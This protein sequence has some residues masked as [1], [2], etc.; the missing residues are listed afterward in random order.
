VISR[1]YHPKSPQKSGPMDPDTPRF[2]DGISS[3]LDT[4]LYKLTMHCAALKYF[5]DVCKSR[6][7]LDSRSNSSLITN[8]VIEDVTYG[9]T[10]RTPHMKLSR[11]AYLWLLEQINS[12]LLITYVLRTSIG[13]VHEIQKLNLV[14]LS[15]LRVSTEEIKFLKSACP[16]LNEA[17]L[18]YLQSFRLKPVEQIDIK[19]TPV[20]DTGNVNDLGNLEYAI[21]GLWVETILYEIPLLALTSEAYFKFC[22]KDWDYEGQE[23][24]AYEKGCT[25]LKNGCIFSEF[26]SRRRRDYHTQDLVMKGLCRAAEDGK[27]NGWKGTLSG[28]SNVQFAM[29]HGV[30]PVGTVAHEWYMTIAAHT[31]NYESANELGLR[32]WVGCFG[33][34]VS[35]S[36]K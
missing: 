4:D 16:Y 35:D 25:L 17:Y 30:N 14:G 3:L 20:N 22:D 27:K 26:G 31:N 23:E 1:N 7:S 19:F 18:E 33:E 21:K 5:P 34:G 8:Y 11:T 13:I 9:F 32:Y 12:K 15:N 6:I 29:N 10:N 2:P 24:R 36:P 28:T